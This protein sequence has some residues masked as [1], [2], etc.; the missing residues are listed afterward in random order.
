MLR[1]FGIEGIYVIHAKKGYEYHE[2]RLRTILDSFN[3]ECEFVTEGDPSLFSKIDL[4]RYFTPEVLSR[5]SPGTI[6]C[7]LNHIISYEKIVANKNKYAIIFENDPFFIGDILQKII[8]ITKKADLLEPGFIVSLEN[9]TLQ[10]PSFWQTCKNKYLYPA[11][12]G[13]CAGAY[14]IDFADGQAL[15]MPG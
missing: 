15:A 14:L 6:S 12:C 10:F 2:Q 1:K 9:T 7:T 11:S 4:E 8:P 3:L 5:Y 13:R